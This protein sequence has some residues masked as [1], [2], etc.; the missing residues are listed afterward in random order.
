MTDIKA[1][2]ARAL[3][4]IGAVGFT[5]D[6]PITFKSGLL[7]PVYVDN[8]RLPFHPTQ[9]HQVIDGFAALLAANK[10]ADDIM[11]GIETGGIPHSSALA[12]A[13]HKPSVIV[14]KQAKDHGTRNR[15]EGGDVGGRHVLLIEDMITMGGSSLSGAQALRDAGAIVGHCCA[16][17]TYGFASAQAAFD[18]AGIHLHTLTDFPAILQEAVAMGHFTTDDADVVTDWLRDPHGWAGRR[19]FGK[20]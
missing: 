2:V 20:G 11:A 5:P 3:L 18:E 4:E 13:L 14:R 19:G 10:I 17:V 7:S 6:A 12:Y 9:W 15:I 1:T 16:V 8:R